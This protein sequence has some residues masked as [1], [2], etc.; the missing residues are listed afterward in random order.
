MGAEL[1]LWR[2]YED[3]SAVSTFELRHFCSST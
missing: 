3:L 1:G 2:E